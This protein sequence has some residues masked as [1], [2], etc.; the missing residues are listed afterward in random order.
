MAL[1]ALRPALPEPLAFAIPARSR[2]RPQPYRLF[3]HWDMEG[4]ILTFSTLTREEAVASIS[5]ICPA[6]DWIE[7]EIHDY[8]AVNFTGRDG[9]SP[10]LLRPDD[11]PGMFHW[12][13]KKGDER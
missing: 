7:R 1:P 9:L 4:R 3:Y 11:P 2:S 10:L 5:S 12:G 6:A 8:F 13:R